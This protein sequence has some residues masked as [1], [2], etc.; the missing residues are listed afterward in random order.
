MKKN[1]LFLF[2]SVFFMLSHGSYAQVAIDETHFP[3]PVFRDFIEVNFDADAD[4]NL[5]EDECASVTEL[6]LRKYPEISTVKGIEFFPGLLGL[7][8]SGTG[9]MSLDV[10]EN[11]L[12]EQL[13][14]SKTGISDLDVSQNPNLFILEC[15][16]TNL[17]DLD[18]SHNAVLEVLDCS[19]TRLKKVEVTNNQDLVELYC[20]GTEITVLDVSQNRNLVALDCG[21]TRLKAVDVTE[22]LALEILDCSDTEVAVIDVS[23]NLALTDLYCEHTGLQSINLKSNTELMALECSGTGLTS[24]DLSNNPMMEYLRCYDTRREVRAEVGGTYDLSRL[25]EFD[26][27]RAFDWKG[28]SVQGSVLT[29]DDTVVTY[30]YVTLYAGEAERIPATLEFKLVANPDAEDDAGISPHPSVVPFAAYAKEGN[31]YL[32]GCQGLVEVFDLQGRRIYQGTSNPV[33]LPLQGVYIVRNQGF[34]LKVLN[35]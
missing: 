24:L 26:V 9:I 32:Q 28:G 30:Q 7:A 29:F 4:G 25:P 33:E 1:Y 12:L 15:D 8:C 10:R 3:D 21:Q 20:A 31:L 2:F 34:S 13:Y 16:E 18:V 6:D 35:L 5:S 23:R 11:P 17:M 19:D 27:S 14:C 22:N